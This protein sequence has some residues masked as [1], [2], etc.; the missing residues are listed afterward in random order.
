MPMVNNHSRRLSSLFIYVLSLFS[1]APLNAADMQLPA[2]KLTDYRGREWQSEDFAEAS[3]LVVAFLGVECPLARQYGPRLQKLADAYESRGVRFLGVDA[4]RQ[5]SLSEMA[6][7]ARQHEIHFP[8]VKDGGGLFAAALG[9]ERTPEVFVFDKHRR[10]RYRGRIDDQYAVGGKSRPQAS[11]EDLKEALEALLSGRSPEINYVPAV[12]CLIARPRPLHPQAEVTYARHIAPL[13]QAHCVE[14]HRPGDIGP[15]SLLDYEEVIGWADM[16]MEVTQQR[17]MP[18]W[19]A[20]PD[21]RQ[22]VNENRLSDTEI[23]LIRRWVEA[24]APLGDPQ[25]LP[26]GRTFVE[27]WQLQREPDMVVTMPQEFSVPA[28]GEVRY[29]YFL[30]DPGLQ[31]DVW[32]NAAEI[33]PGNRSVVHHVI[34]FVSSDGRLADDDRQLLTAYVPGLRVFP[35]PNHMAKL[36]PAGAKFIFQMHYTPNGIPQT[37]RTKIGLY[38]AREEDVTHRVQTISTRTRSFKIQPML[39]DQWFR[40]IPVKLPIDV[41]LLSL[42]PHMHLRGQAFKFRA[43]WPDGTQEV[44]LDVPHYDFNWQT[45]YRLREP[46]TLPAG[47]TLVADAS[48]DNSP[49]NLANPDPSAVVT[50]GDQSWEEMLIGYAEIAYPRHLAYDLNELSRQLRRGFILED[51]QL[52]FERLD[53]NHDQTLSPHEVPDRWRQRLLLL[54]RNGDGCVSRDEFEARLELLE[55]VLSP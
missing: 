20:H 12:G 3:V 29:Q 22:F 17:R 24:G 39:S 26:P 53:K 6:S 38:F 18:P 5:D 33:V 21:H 15:L 32:V 49:R 48:F 36:I 54:D 41:T 9:A 35:L 31:H 34:V 46:R 30:V 45:A 52:L 1:I 47:T 4:N 23:E 42:S 8:M 51:L 27:G 16:I 13:L 37:D 55:K 50:W 43:L 2:F 44:L 19:H 7:Y 28:E 10:L 40:S 25:E 11:R 14:C